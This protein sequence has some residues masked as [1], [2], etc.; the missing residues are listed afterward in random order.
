MKIR[1][2]IT[3]CI[4]LY[5]ALCGAAF[6]QVIH[7]P[8]PNLRVALRESLNLPPGVPL[9][10]AAIRSLTSLDAGDRGIVDLTG[11]EHA[12]ELTLLIIPR[13]Q[14]TNL[15][16]IAA[17]TKLEFLAI[18]DNP[19]SDIIPLSK[20]ENLQRLDASG[21]RVSDINPLANLTQL[22]RIDLRHNAISDIQ[23]LAD[24]GIGPIGTDRK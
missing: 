5:S 24:L 10:S 11:L 1:Q 2:K 12:T 14:I 17:L 9:T 7:I 15:A 13:Y 4:L 21:C 6:A 3:L 16:P 23:P 20:L 22:T 8:D 18:A 19:I